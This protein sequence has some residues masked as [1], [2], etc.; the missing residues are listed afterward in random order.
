MKCK[1]PHCKS[2]NF[3]PL[4]EDGIIRGIT[5]KNCGARYS[6]YEV[7]IKDEVN[8]EGFWNSV[9]WKAELKDTVYLKGAKKK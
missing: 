8:R 5:C 9:V 1:N 4:L 7:D 6:E 2:T 3:I